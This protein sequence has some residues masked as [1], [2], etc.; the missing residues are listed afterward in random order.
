MNQYWFW[1]DWHRTGE[2]TLSELMMVSNT[3]TSMHHIRPQWVIP[4]HMDNEIFRAHQA[5]VLLTVFRL[6]LKFNQNLEC[7]SL[8]YVQ[9]ITTKFCT[10]HDSITVIMCAK[11]PFDRLST[12][13]TRAQ[14]ILV[15]FRIWSKYI[16]SLVG[17]VPGQRDGY[18]CHDSLSH[19][20]ISSCDID[21]DK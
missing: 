4:S 12:F 2:K 6:N 18:R 13:Y 7:S 16:V 15:E 20:D 19:Q 21:H 1:Y 17:W 14:Q 8:K 9:P 10:C 5:P 11:F 3:D